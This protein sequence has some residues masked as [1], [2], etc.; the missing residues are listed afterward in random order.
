MFLT[1]FA[2]SK[3][4]GLW[5]RK[6]STI[7]RDSCVYIFVLFFFFFFIRVSRMN[8]CVWRVVACGD[9]KYGFCYLGFGNREVFWLCLL[10]MGRVV[11][12]IARTR[13][14][15]AVWMNECKHLDQT[16]CVFRAARIAEMWYIDVNK[17]RR[18]T[19][20]WQRP[21]RHTHRLPNYMD[22]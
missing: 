14:E 4:R 3:L 17:G 13:K 22:I 10:N 19:M 2:S 16:L 8:P 1:H 9:D 6:I 11:L 18:A 7:S 20:A 15:V 5:Q 12:V 21:E